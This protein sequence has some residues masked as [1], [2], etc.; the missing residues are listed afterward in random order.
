MMSY[1][2]SCNAEIHLLCL[3]RSSSHSRAFFNVIFTVHDIHVGHRKWTAPSQRGWKFQHEEAA[4]R[5]TA[6]S[7][8]AQ[9]LITSHVIRDI[10]RAKGK[11]L[12]TMIYGNWSLFLIVAQAL[13]FF[14]SSLCALRADRVRV[15]VFILSPAQR[16]TTEKCKIQRVVK[17]T[18]VLLERWDEDSLGF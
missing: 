14:R 17:Q 11:M 9:R 2:Q 16:T 8:L 1:R 5:L 7:V 15:P 3:Y 13:E 4:V 6:I 18:L 10:V 12:L